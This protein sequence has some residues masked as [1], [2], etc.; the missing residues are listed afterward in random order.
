MRE[1]SCRSGGDPSVATP[2]SDLWRE[3]SSFSGTRRFSICLKA[4][5][6]LC[7]ARTSMPLYV[8]SP[9]VFPHIPPGNVEDKFR[10]EEILGSG[11]SSVCKVYDKVTK[12]PY[13]CKMLSKRNRSFDAQNV[14]KEVR[15]M[16]KLSG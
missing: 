1:V 15:I 14:R 16:L 3:F 10:K 9:A 8:K 11:F 4:M 12:I 7:V 5:A 13:A 6:Q 2:T